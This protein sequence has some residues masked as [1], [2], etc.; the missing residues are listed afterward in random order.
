MQIQSQL[1]YVYLCTVYL[2]RKGNK[3]NIQR[4]NM[5]INR[6]HEEAPLSTYNVLVKAKGND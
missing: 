6:S 5:T 4:L 3:L 2:C 1:L